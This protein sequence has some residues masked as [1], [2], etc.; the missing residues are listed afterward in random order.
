MTRQSLIFFIR[1]EVES[2]GLYFKF[3][4]KEREISLR[5]HAQVALVV[6]TLTCKSIF[7]I[8][9]SSPQFLAVLG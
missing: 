5:F 7:A 2:Q 1:E 6:K 4:N 8:V 9:I 3:Q